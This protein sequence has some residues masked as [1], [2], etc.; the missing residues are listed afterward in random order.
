A[1]NVD[2]AFLVAAL[3][4]DF[5]PRRLERYLAQCWDSGV[6]PVIVLNKAD[7]CGDVRAHI[8]ETERIAIGAPVIALSA[9]TGQG[10]EVLEKLL[11]PGKTIVLLG[12]SGVGKSTL[13]NRLLQEEKQ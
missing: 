3:D 10:M 1:A 5:S 2:M 12:S 7:E 9:R 13:V 4:M 6:A 8:A 11:S